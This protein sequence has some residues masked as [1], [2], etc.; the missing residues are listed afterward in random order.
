MKYVAK[1]PIENEP[2]L[3]QIRAWR[4]TGEKPLSEQ[5]MMA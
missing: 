4:R 5:P 3:V 1:G 2:S